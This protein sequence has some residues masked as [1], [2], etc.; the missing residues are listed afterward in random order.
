M[1]KNFDPKISLAREFARRFGKTHVVVLAL[2][3]ENALEYASYGSSKN[4]CN[5][6][7]KVAD[8]AF[9]AVVKFFKEREGKDEGKS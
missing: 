9:E 3:E 7:K 4:R 2:D 1:P 5:Q 6:A 8:V